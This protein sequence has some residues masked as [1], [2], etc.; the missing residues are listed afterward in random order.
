MTAR[1]WRCDRGAAFAASSRSGLSGIASG[2]RRHRKCGRPRLINVYRP[3]EF[4]RA[5]IQCR[6]ASS[7]TVANHTCCGSSSRIFNK[8]VLLIQWNIHLPP[9]SPIDSAEV[10]EDVPDR[11]QRIEMLGWRISY[12]RLH[13]SFGWYEVLPTYSTVAPNSILG[14]C[15]HLHVI[16]YGLATTHTCYDYGFFHKA[17]STRPSQN[18]TS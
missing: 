7:N 12:V 4:A 5:T 11:T 10:R 17:R 8:G 1:L 14:A 16:W 2:N 13:F 6:E 3:M 18:G 9:R 15:R